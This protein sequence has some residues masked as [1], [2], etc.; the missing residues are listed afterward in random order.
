MFDIYKVVGTSKGL[1]KRLIVGSYADWFSVVTAV[2]LLLS[3]SDG[4]TLFEVTVC[5]HR[6]KT[7]NHFKTTTTH[8]AT[9]DPKELHAFLWG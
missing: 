3:L 1:S 5:D 7:S 9:L 8:T 2:N 4:K 6:M